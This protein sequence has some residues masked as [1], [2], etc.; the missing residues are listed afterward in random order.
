MFARD[1]HRWLR[2]AILCL[3]LFASTAS[4]EGINLAWNHCLGEGT[5]VQNV[6]FA[7]DTNVGSSVMTASFLLGSDFP[8]VTGLEIILDLATSSAALPP[9]WT[10]DYATACRPNGLVADFVADPT[11]THCAD[12]S[13][14]LGVGGV[15]YCT[16]AVLCMDHPLAANAARVK[17]A[18]A[19]PLTLARDLSAGQEYFACHLGLRHDHTVGD[20]ACAGCDVPACI[21]LNS[22]NLARDRIGDR[23]LVTPAGPGSNF[24]AW[25]GGGSPVVGTSIGCPA[26]TATR[27]SAWGAV[28]SLYR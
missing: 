23:K 27:R 7:C 15:F 24:V 13:G 8:A 3:C 2:P 4:A 12:W 16:S 9:W 1:R 19:V 28:K 26:A 17:V 25:Q 11:E 18:V 14:G 20:G 21:V 22:I 6:T 10:L 5:G